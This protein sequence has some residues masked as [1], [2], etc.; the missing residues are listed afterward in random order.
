M[1]A[2]SWQSLY[3]YIANCI[4]QLLFWKETSVNE[5]TS[6]A[7]FLLRRAKGITKSA[8]KFPQ[9]EIQSYV[10]AAGAAAKFAELSSFSIIDW[11]ELETKEIVIFRRR[12]R[13]DQGRFRWTQTLYKFSIR[14]KW[15]QTDAENT[16]L[17]HKLP[18]HCTTVCTKAIF[19]LKNS[20]SF[21][22]SIKKLFW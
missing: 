7:S 11:A 10:L 15:R 18:V 4:F 17:P 1:W 13:K 8:A 3:L 2:I 20:V 22:L 14:S 21:F 12:L 5:M 19:S 6:E 9:F 16:F